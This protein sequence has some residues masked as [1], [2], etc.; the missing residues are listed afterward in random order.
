MSCSGRPPIRA[1]KL[2]LG[3]VLLDGDERVTVEVQ[4]ATL[5]MAQRGTVRVSA[6]AMIRRAAPG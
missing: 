1:R 2:G 3:F 6:Q 4:I 5:R